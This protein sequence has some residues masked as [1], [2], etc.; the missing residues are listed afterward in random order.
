MTLK[1]GFA[2]ILRAAFAAALAFA[3]AAPSGAQPVP[4]SP[5]VA[6]DPS[7]ADPL[8]SWNIRPAPDPL[9]GFTP[10]PGFPYPERPAF[11][12]MARSEL[13]A[14]RRI[15]CDAFLRG[16]WGDEASTERRVRRSCA[17]LRRSLA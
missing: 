13:K 6:A 4:T 15:G 12:K 14:G 16:R 3:A 1:A 10:S 9:S 2:L 7:P 17:E 11:P 8:P 5:A